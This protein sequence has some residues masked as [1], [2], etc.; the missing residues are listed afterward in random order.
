MKVLAIGAGDI[1]MHHAEA[2]ERLDG[3]MIG[4]FDV[5]EKNS[6]KFS[7]TYNCPVITYEQIPEYVPQADYVLLT[8]PPTKR[9]DY[10]EMVLSQHVPLY[11]EKPIAATMEDA[12]KLRDMA[13]KYDGNIIVNFAH[14]YR[15]PFQKML[16]IIESGQLGDPVS[17][18]IDRQGPAYGFRDSKLPPSWRTDPNLACGMTVESL[19][20]EWKLMTAMAGSFKH[21]ACNTNSTVEDLPQYDNISNVTVRF[22]NGASGA[23]VASWATDIS[24]SIRG[25]VGT[26]GSVMMYGEGMF[27]YDWVKW[28]TSDMPKPEII[29]FKDSYKFA[30][31]DVLWNVHKHFQE[32]LKEGKPNRSPLEDGISALEY[33]LAAVKSSKE[34][35]TVPVGDWGKGE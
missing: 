25:F 31:T 34:G 16:E 35:I 29:E 13:E 20:H 10:V 17:I 24:H 12:Y 32:C 11:M 3:Q 30:T 14:F 26:K 15:P 19:S 1:A 21:I 8:T 23:V 18:I 5:S 4:V 6:A 33:S 22:K 28:K 27:E 2:I 7:A 9:L